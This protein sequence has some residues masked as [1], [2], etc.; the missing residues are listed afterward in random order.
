MGCQKKIAE[1]IVDAKA[2]YVWTLKENQPTLHQEVRDFFE[3]AQADGWRDMRHE[4]HETMGGEHGRIETRRV[5]VSD[6]IEWMTDRRWGRGLRSVVMIESTRTLGGE[7]TTLLLEQPGAGGRD[8]S[9]TH[10]GAL[11]D[12]E[13]PALG[14]GHG[15]RRRPLPNS[16]QSTTCATVR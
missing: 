16:P 14:S 1:S 7:S 15:L 2:D 5:V 8:E 4:E 13:R 9:R 6:D 10:S 11:G 12:R 3:S